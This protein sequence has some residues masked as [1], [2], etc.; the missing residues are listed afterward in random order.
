MS[1]LNA[2][3]CTTDDNI[4]VFRYRSMIFDMWVHDYKAVC[5]MPLWPLWDLDLWPQ[6]QRH[7]KVL[8]CR[9]I[10]FLINTFP[11]LNKVDWVVNICNITK[12]KVCSITL[13][14]FEIGQW[15]LVCWCMTIRRCVTYRNDLCGTLTFDL[16]V[17]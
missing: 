2:A 16:K 1:P 5:R 15:Y 4:F 3:I 12:I 11:F 14:S 7:N 13:L 10:G 17:K 9:L 8:W 6:G